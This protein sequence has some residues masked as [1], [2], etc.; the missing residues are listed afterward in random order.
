MEGE[1]AAGLEEAEAAVPLLVLGTGFGA[2][3]A[4]PG[5]LDAA[6]A[7]AAAVSVAPAVA[8]LSSAKVCGTHT[9]SMGTFK[10][11]W[12]ARCGKSL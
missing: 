5:M 4:V 8:E 6:A 12:S 10:P 2:Q 1:E 9:E 11:I 7:A 3:F